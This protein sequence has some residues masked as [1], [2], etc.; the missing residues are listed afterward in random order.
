MVI[1]MQDICWLRLAARKTGTDSIPTEAAAKLVRA[2]LIKAEANG[3]C[4]KITTRGELAL[5]RL[6]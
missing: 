1:T 3:A 2:Q 6:G 4:M 5:R